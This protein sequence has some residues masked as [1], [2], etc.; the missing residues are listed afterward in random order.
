MNL[1]F[2]EVREIFSSNQVWSG[3]KEVNFYRLAWDALNKGG[4]TVYSNIIE[5][6]MV[7]VR[8]YTLIMLY[9]EFCDLAFNEIFPYEFADW[10]EIAGISSFEIGLII[11]RNYDKYDYLVDLGNDRLD[12]IFMALV[13]EQRYDVMETLSNNVDSSGGA[14]SVLVA[15]YAATIYFDDIPDLYYDGTD[16]SELDKFKMYNKE[17]EN[18]YSEILKLAESEILDAY[19]W[20]LEGTYKIGHY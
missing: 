2:Q 8:A 4:L 20:A 10:E 7:T 16:I 18:N 15:M 13:E 5:R 14:M 19:S 1:S 6:N 11:G 9:C 3:N 17:I 12:D